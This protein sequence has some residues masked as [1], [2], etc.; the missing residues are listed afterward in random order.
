M[1]NLLINRIDIHA[2]N[3]AL[4]NSMPEEIIRW[5]LSLNQPTIATTSFGPGSAALLRMLTHADPNKT[6]PVVWV[7]SGFNFRETYK[8]ARTDH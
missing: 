4:R 7:D 1:E 5:A 6:V 3:Y 2:E 8:V